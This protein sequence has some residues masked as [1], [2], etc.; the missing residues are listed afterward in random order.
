MGGKSKDAEELL[1]KLKE[2]NRAPMTIEPGIVKLGSI[3]LTNLTCTVVLLNDTEIPDVRL[4]AAVDE[5]PDLN[6]KDGLVQIP[7]E[8]STVLVAMIGNDSATRFIL[9]FSKVQEVLMYDGLNGGL[10]KV[11]SLV[12]KL[13]NLENKVNALITWGGTLSPPFSPPTQ[14]TATVRADIENVKVKH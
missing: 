1:R 4:K 8:E 11:V 12:T 7:V 3:D 10:I 5:I 9:A 2:L 14:L 13:N 6:T